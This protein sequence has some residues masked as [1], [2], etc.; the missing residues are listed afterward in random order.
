M[1]KKIKPTKNSGYTEDTSPEAFSTKQPDDSAPSRDTHKFLQYPDGGQMPIWYRHQTKDRE[2]VFRG[3]TDQKKEEIVVT[4]P[5][6][7]VH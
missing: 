3:H 7:V 4:L 1:P 2:V 5:A 6:K